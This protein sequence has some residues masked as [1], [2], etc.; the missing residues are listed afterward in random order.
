MSIM[1]DVPVFI[2]AGGFGTRLKEHTEFRP[3]PMLEI[4]HRPIL[5]HIMR[6][7]GWHGFKRFVICSGF[8]S[9]VIKEY[10]LN[11]GPLNSDFTV[12][13]S[14]HEVTYH[15][16]HHD[17]DW[18]VTI[19]YTG[20]LA[21]TGARLARAAGKYLGPAQHFAVTYGDGL[22]DVDL[23]GEF[24]FHRQHNRIGTMLAVN[25]PPSRFGELRVDINTVTDFSEK[26]ASRDAWINGG[27]FFFRR[28][29]LQYLS[30]D[31]QSVLEKD[32]L[33]KLARDR[34]LD[35]YRHE[36][37]WACMDTQRDR[38]K[39]E[40]LWASGRAPWATNSCKVMTRDID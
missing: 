16:P 23:V 20:E 31:E 28:E 39:L 15:G 34:Q 36:G 1:E 5:W 2:L 19:T 6:W 17:E 27:Y 26:P 32:P 3:K 9:E 4:G 8:R 21:M 40:E 18:D 7:Y 14:T 13:L 11:Y 25:A 12:N 38:D 29:F 33:V 30:S 22:C 37:F 24:G 10:F 35:I